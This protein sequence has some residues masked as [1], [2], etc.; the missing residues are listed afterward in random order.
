MQ[1][2]RKKV[3]SELYCAIEIDIK[4]ICHNQVIIH[5]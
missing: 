3:I 2:I 4:S 1:L 5:V